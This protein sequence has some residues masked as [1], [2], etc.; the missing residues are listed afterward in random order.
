MRCGREAHAK[1]NFM[2]E[3]ESFGAELSAF[4]RRVD[5]LRSARSL[6]EGEHLPTLDAALFEL[7]HAAEVLWPRYEQLAATGRRSGNRDEAHEQQVLRAIFQRLPVAVVLLDRD[8]VVRR[9]N[10]S[11]TQ[12]FGMRAGYAAG[13]PL[14]GSFTHEGRGAF[15]TQVAAVARGEGARS[16]RVDLLHSPGN[17]DA[18]APTKQEAGTRLRV[19][20]T[21]LRPPQEP[22]T[23]VLAVF[24]PAVNG[25]AGGPVTTG[26][27]PAESEAAAAVTPDLGEISRH[28]ELLDLIDDLVSELLVAEREPDVI[29]ARAAAVLHKRFADWVVVDLRG[30]NEHLRRSVVLGPDDA[31]RDALKEQDPSTAPL[32][33]EAAVN[34]VSTLQSRP[35]EPEAFGTDSAGAAMLVRAEAGSLIC[36]PLTRAAHTDDTSQTDG[37]DSGPGPGPCLTRGA[38]TLFRTGGGR[39]FELAEAEAVGRMAGHIALALGRCEL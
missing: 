37:Q 14:S 24:Q 33:T 13:R 6:P 36:A 29:A 25:A 18:P 32:V 28:T 7:Q 16:L 8:G 19:T 27:Q 15:H 5:E 22:R 39:A 10:V 9:L 21:S 20:L 26:V 34:G 35:E 30:E 23:G 4:R 38:L 31:A 3:P 17:G 1:L 11:A 2:T 12:L